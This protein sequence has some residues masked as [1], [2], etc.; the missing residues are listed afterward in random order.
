M[1]NDDRLAGYDGA[2]VTTPLTAA[3]AT[4][5]PS[6][7]PDTKSLIGLAVAAIVVAA[8]Y[9]A[10]DVLVPITLAVMLSFVLSP[11]TNLLRRLGLWRTASVA[12]SIL[13][14]LAV[15]GMLG[16][17]LG[18]QAAGLAA[19][20]PR[21]ADQIEQKIA[22]AQALATA[23][24]DAVRRSLRIPGETLAPAAVP[25][26]AR[27]GSRA[28]ATAARVAS[29][30]Q[31][32]PLLVELAQPRTS[33]LTVARTIL[34]PILGPLETTFIVLIVAV[35]IL[36]QKEDLRDRF[37]RVFGSTDLHRTTLALDEAGERLSRFFIS[38]L[39]VNTCF[40]LVIG[41]GL[42]ALGVPT[43][44]L[45]GGLAGLLRFV[46]YIGP[47]LAV[48][49]P[50]A[51]GAAIEPTW[52][53][54][55]AVGVLFV[56]VEPLTAYV[57]E[58]LLYGHS[59]GLSPASVIVA[60]IFWTWLWGPIGLIMST[61][62]TLCLVVMGRHVKS[63]E[64]FDVLLGDRP[65]LSAVDTFYQRILADNPNEALANAERLLAE[66]SLL[67]Y[68]DTVVLPALKLAAADQAI[69][70]LR[71]ERSVEMSQSML[72]IIDELS[73]HV[74]AVP[75]G[76]AAAAG[77][78]SGAPSHVAA[79]VAGRG[80]FDDAV[81]AML[82]QLLRQRGVTTRLIP[83]V[84][85]SRD[86]IAT[87]DLAGVTVCVV[88]Y[89]E[90]AGMPTRLRSLVARLRSRLP[91]ARIVVGLWPEG[92]AMLRDAKAQQ[93]LGADAYVGSLRAAVDAVVT[94]AAAVDQKRLPVET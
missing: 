11:L 84:A 17:L 68:Y 26:P 10:Q 45:W 7:A 15:I 33:A 88:S 9:L 60:A 78:P 22:G 37:I 55:I 90:L 53:T 94:A 86:G 3:G 71:R 72:A 34:E 82:A 64:F 83:H 66:R 21:Y 30:S 70:K 18:S 79:C 81:A 40:G 58:P 27:S 31:Q 62:L 6:A 92:D 52:W 25:P 49:P 47:I 4:P 32:E 16:T 63:L 20:A 67:D 51:L 23:R 48:V 39:G 5:A 35:F 1:N 59:T 38:Q 85:A 44:A 43:P 76:A 87:L 46:P 50:L 73:E 28:R 69:G 91:S 42:W 54:A 8:L 12:L 13:V 41:L 24:F 80:P 65:P 19:D 14:A 74:D 89:L 61:P 57:V 29:A 93:P 56:V 75:S 77:Q 2:R 36:V